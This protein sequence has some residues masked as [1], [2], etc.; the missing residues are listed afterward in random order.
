MKAIFVVL[1]LVGTLHLLLISKKTYKVPGHTFL[2][3]AQYKEF[4]KLPENKSEKVELIGSTRLYYFGII[5][6]PCINLFYLAYAALAIG[7]LLLFPNKEFPGIFVGACFFAWLT[8][9]LSIT[10]Y[11]YSSANQKAA[12]PLKKDI[13]EYQKL[14]D[15]PAI[16]YRNL[17]HQRDSLAQLLK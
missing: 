11:H 7:F 9:G 4:L 5:P 10:I 6:S 1:I 15:E 8:I 17:S 14:L 16:I 3:E 13:E 12:I 2:S